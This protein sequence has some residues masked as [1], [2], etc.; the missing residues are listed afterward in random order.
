MLAV[1]FG[2]LYVRSLRLRRRDSLGLN[3]ASAA[4]AVEAAPR[5]AVAQCAG[6]QRQSPSLPVTH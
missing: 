1:T 4:I 2:R 5:Y 6:L 3:A